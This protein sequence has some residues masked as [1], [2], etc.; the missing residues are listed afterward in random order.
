M[1]LPTGFKNPRKR[2][3]NLKNK[4]K[5]CFLWCHVRDIN[6]WKE[7]PERILKIDK[8]IAEKLNYD[9]FEFPVQEKFFD[10]IEVKKQYLH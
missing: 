7:N 8:K 3:I 10:R 6:P 5:K 4:D 2:L 1:N 9:K